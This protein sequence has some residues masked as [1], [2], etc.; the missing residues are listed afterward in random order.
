MLLAEST[1]TLWPRTSALQL[2]VFIIKEG[3]E[4]G[5]GGQKKEKGQKDSNVCVCVQVKRHKIS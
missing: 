2:G 3:E 5:G 1:Q 4:G